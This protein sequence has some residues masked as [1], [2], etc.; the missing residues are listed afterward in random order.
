MGVGASAQTVL[1]E[2]SFDPST[3]AAW[4]PSPLGLFSNWSTSS[5][6]A[7]YNGGGHTQ[8]YA[9]DAGW[10]DYIV[11]AR[12]R[13]A[14][15]SDH[16]GGLRGRINPAGGRSY[17]VWIYPSTGHL[18]LYR[19]AAWNI[20]TT[21]LT[22]LDEYAVPG[23]IA[24]S[25]FHTLSLTFQGTQISV[26]FNSSTVISVT[27]LASG[28]PAVGAVALDVSNQ[29][30]EFDDVAVTTIPVVST[31]FLS[32]D[33][34]SGLTSWT[35]SPLGLSTG[36]S[37]SSGTAAYDGGGHTQLY[38]GST[39]WTDYRV[40]AKVRVSLAQNHPGGLRGRVDTS[41]GASY[42]AWIYPGSSVIKLF[43]VAAWNIDT[44]GLTLLGE[45]TVPGGIAASTFHGLALSFSGQRVSVLWN[46][47]LVLSVLDTATGAPA[48]GA[49]ALDVSNR[50]VEFDDVSVAT[51][52]IPARPLFGD[53]FDP[54]TPSGFWAASP[55]GRLAN[56]STSTGTAAYN[57]SGH[58]QL[59]AGS[60]A[61]TDY[62]VEATFVLDNGSDHP[63][64]L[65][66]RVDL[67]TGASYAAWI[68]PSSG[69][70]KLFRAAAWHIDTTGLELLGQYT[71]TGGIS[72]GVAHTLALDFEGADV[73]VLYGGVPVITYTDTGAALSAGAIA[74][75]VSNQ[76][77]EWDD[78][79]VTAPTA[80]DPDAF[81]DAGPG[82]PLLVIY[83][84]TRPFSRYA[85]EILR[86]EGLNHFATAEVGDL[87]PTLLAAYD[88]A[89][90]GE[91][92]LTSGQVTVLSDWV[93]SGGNLIAFRPD[94]QL[95][96][97]L[98]LTSASST[99]AEAYLQIATGSAPGAGLPAATLQFHGTADRYTLSGATAVATLYADAS[100]STSNPA[101]TLRSVGSNGGQAAAFTFDLA[102][103]IAWTRQGNPA[104]SGQ[105]RDGVTPI[106]PNDLFFGDAS[107]DPQ[108]DWIDLDKVA[109]PQA[110]EQQ[111]LLVN[112]VLL[113]NADKKPLPRFWYFPRGEKAVVLMTGDDHANGGTA[114]RFADYETESPTAC[115]VEDWECVRGTSYI[116]PNTPLTN[117]AA[118]ALHNDGFEIGLHVNT[119]CANWTP[120]SLETFYTDQLAAFAAAYPGLPAPATNRTHCIAWSDFA[121]QAKVEKR[122]G[123]RLDTNYYYWPGS[124]IDDRPGFMTG[125]GLALRF[126]DETG[127]LL[128]V[129]QVSTQMTDESGQTFPDT[130]D[131]LL[132]KALGSEGYYGIMNA[133]M[134]TDS[135]SSM[136]SDAIVASALTRGVPI[137]TARQLLT[138]ID[139]RNSSS[140]GNLSWSG[141]TLSFTI[142]A[143]PG[144]NGLTALLP[145]TS[146]AGTLSSL[147]VGSSSVS[148]TT[149]T[150]KGVSYAVFPA[151]TGSWQAVYV[152]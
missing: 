129:F 13:L 74:L 52:A 98:G 51:E 134:H 104:W 76:P 56:W 86:A 137:V 112:L 122:H 106:R 126:A 93:D 21:G 63:G 43:R 79:V 60:A 49:V 54:A 37:A 102:R 132:D 94:T 8:I 41:T 121:S 115:S 144:A 111:R 29:P 147:T 14:N 130:I 50:P 17:A 2:D 92:P 12:F 65:R 32:D 61:W 80:P 148:F 59:Y 78:V 139:S 85:T 44:T 69:V 96:S 47:A 127:Q 88:V 15:G 114:G 133:N 145:E 35:S 123:I 120:A 30:I 140:F 116:Y 1:F 138:W 72:S 26:G 36:W 16:P 113:M 109:I 136:G 108:P 150:I 67:V 55:L 149:E 20:D 70:L 124:W 38:A 71:V 18:R 64:G 141:G 146:A 22:L 107:A 101:V 66:G 10:A 31:S 118:V 45:Y 135:S 95:A 99:L 27:D 28:A 46:D 40:S 58:T 7:S 91:M 75:D 152:P 142:T 100:T 90:L 81:I 125:S 33:F 97:L 57:G 34:A 110:D 119:G 4:K 24:A 128:D 23:G 87:T 105:E 9:G 117:T 73:R 83:D 131:D 68:Y 53:D 19:V 103:S 25:T 39:S 143:A 5:G 48:A 151:S 89:I 77:V 84:A 82:G 11:S 6:N 42:A 62:T 3:L